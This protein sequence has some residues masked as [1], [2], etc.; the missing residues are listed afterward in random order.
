MNKYLPIIKKISL[1]SS[2]IIA[3]VAIAL[4]LCDWVFGF[5]GFPS[6][7]SKRISHP[8]NYEKVMQNIEFQYTFKTNNRGLRYHDISE[9]KPSNTNRIFVSGDSFTEGL[10]VD[11]GKRF[12]DLL[13]DQFQQSD[14]RVLFI[15]G[16]LA[17]SG[18]LHYGN[19]FLDVGL[20][21]NPD[22]LLICLFVNDLGDTPEKLIWDPVNPLTFSAQ[23]VRS[24]VKE[25]TYTLWPHVY[26]QLKLL[27]SQREYQRKTKTTDFILTISKQA[28]KHNIPQSQIKIWKESLPQE[29][30]SAINRD[31]FIGAILSHGLLY[32]EYLSD[33]IDISS[34]RAL[35][36]WKTMTTILAEILDHAKQSDVETAVILIP[37]P[38][39][40]DPNR[41]NET[42]PWIIAGSE[43]REEW[44]WEETEIQKK[45][46]L[47]ALSEEVLFLDLTPVF[48]EAVKSNKSLNW[49]LD[50]HW[51]PRGHEVA[52]AA[53]ASWLNDQQVFS[54]I[55]SKSLTNH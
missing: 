34:P 10:G 12:T 9:E 4:F 23:S 28:R 53:I 33:S 13:E 22:A 21:Y 30:V 15:N 2:L 45:M 31:Q 50:D 18:P 1:N 19:L 55:K 24:G 49:E 29:L 35:K 16:G 41:H 40:Y 39:Q 25:I 36:K 54:F 37:S 52:A 11:D 38:F 17:G 43:I 20:D 14:T 27:Y 5:L 44:L 6:E 47:W 8:V 48:R 26:T 32:P 7:V 3:S 46:R 42:N 51:N